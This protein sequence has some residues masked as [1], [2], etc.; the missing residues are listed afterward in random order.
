MPYS[1]ALFFC[2]IPVV[3]LE[4][5]LGQ[6]FQTSHVAIIRRMS[7]RAIGLGWASVIGT[8]LLVQFYSALLAITLVYLI[9]SLAPGG[10]PWSH[11]HAHRFFN[12]SVVQA[13]GRVDD[14]GDGLVPHL[15]VAYAVVWGIVAVSASRSS[16]SIEMLNWLV[17]PAPFVI[18]V[19][20]FIRGITLDGAGDGIAAF[21]TPDFRPLLSSEVWHWCG[22]PSSA[23]VVQRLPTCAC[24]YPL[25]S[26][27]TGVDGRGWT[28]LL[29]SI[30]GPRHTHHLR[31]V[32]AARRARRPLRHHRLPLQLS[33]CE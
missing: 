13:S 32:H 9:A 5:A 1:C 10:L 30:C 12:E 11:G 16:A 31:L 17:M 14:F 29:W 20:F 15:A 33:L 6:R 2:A 18:L 25:G 19:V 3:V 8:F 26:A 7:P 23:I 27:R 24:R 28:A 22:T 4:F 21:L